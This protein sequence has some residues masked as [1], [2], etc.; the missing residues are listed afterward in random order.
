MYCFTNFI[1]LAIEEKKLIL[2]WRNDESI[3]KWM[4]N[5]DA[6]SLDK[7]L[8]FIEMLRKDESKFYFLV[9]RKGVPVGVVSLIDIKD[10]IGDW[11]YYIA[12]S[13]HNKNLGVEFYHHA[14]LYFFT[15]LK[16]SKIIGY[17]LKDNKSANSFSDLFGFS[18]ALQLKE[19]GEATQ[20]YYFREIT[21]E[22]WKE[23][24]LGN[25]KIDRLLQLTINY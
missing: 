4:Y 2:E 10:N 3:R 22:I 8:Q 13:F 11:G 5:T 7:H 25:P 14:L 23:T 21:A 16:F 24:V 1:E 17:V 12:P 20:E 19:I 18:K 15:T 6:I 9:K